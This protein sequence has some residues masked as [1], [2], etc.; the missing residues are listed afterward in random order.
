MARFVAG[1]MQLGTRSGAH[2]CAVHHNAKAGGFRGASAIHANVDARIS[3]ERPEGDVTNTVFVRCEKQR[4]KPFAPFALRGEEI[5]LPY[6]DEYEEEIT[7]LVFQLA[8][9]ADIPTVK[10]PKTKQADKTVARLLEVFDKVA[11]D[12]A[13]WGGVKVGFWKEAVEEA[14]PPI[15]EERTFWK[16]RKSLEK[17]GEIWEC[18]THGGSPLFQR[19]GVTASTAS[20]ASSEKC[21]SCSQGAKASDC[22][23]TNCI[24]PLGDA[25]GAVH[26]EAPGAEKPKSKKA[27]ASAGSEPYTAPLLHQDPDEETALDDEATGVD[28]E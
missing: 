14:D 22:N 12:G 17:S 28:I 6:P 24:N 1:M 5:V 15:C 19:K 23:C 16:Y 18:G 26:N 2:V 10:H 27:R 21:S 7:S 25:V 13:Q 4:G 20:T 11:L 8:G 9:A 3:L